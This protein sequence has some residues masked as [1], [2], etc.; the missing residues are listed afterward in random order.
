MKIFSLL[1]IACLFS[2]MAIAQPSVAV[3]GFVVDSAGN[4]LSNASIKVKFAKDSLFTQTKKDGSFHFRLQG[5][6]QFDMLITMVGF[7]AHQKKY[8]ITAGDTALAL[9]RILLLPNDME[10]EGVVVVAQTPVKVMEDTTQYAVSA[11]K[12]REGA[13]AEEVIKKLPGLEVDKDGN[14]TSQGKPVKRI[15]V[16]GKDFFGGD[17]QTATQ[18]LPAEVLENIQIIEDY[19]DQANLTGIKT[20]EPETIININTRKDKNRGKFGSL[21]AGVGTRDRYMAGLMYNIFDDEQQISL[22]GSFNN[23]NVATFNFNGGGRGGGARAGNLGGAERG[24]FGG[25]GLT[26]AIS[27]GINYRDKWNEKMSVDGSYSVNWSSNETISE[28]QSQD[29]NPLI[30]RITKSNRVSESSN[31]NHRF[32]F[33]FDYR[34]D[35]VNFLK[36]T[37]YFSYSHNEGQNQSNSQLRRNKYYTYNVGRSDNKSYAPNYGGTVLFNHKFNQR[38]RNLSISLSTNFSARTQAG[39][40]LNN[41][42]NIDSGYVPPSI[43]DTIQQQQSETLSD[44]LTSNARI[45]Y[46]EPLD[47]KRNKFL[48]MSYEWN[49]SANFSDRNVFDVLQTSKDPLP[50][51]N[52]SN[53][54]NYQFTTHRTALT[55]KGMYAK[56]N[57]LV[58][59]VAQPSLLNGESV[60]KNIRIN[61]RNMN[62][63]PSARFAYNIG[64]DHTINM[65]VGGRSREPSFN[66]LQPISDSSNLNNIVKGNP[67]LNAET[68]YNLSIRYNKSDRK[69][70]KVLFANFNYDITDDKIVSAR[71]NNVSGTG[72]TTTYMNTDGFYRIAA[73]GSF[74]QPFKKRIFSVTT[75]LDMSYDN[76]ISFTDSFQNK[77]QNW[78]LR[79]GLIF[80]LDI[81]EV[82]DLNFDGGFTYYKTTT[83]YSTY[84]TNNEARTYRIGVSGKHFFFK[85]LTIG[86][87]LYKNFNSGFGSVGAVN[88]FIINTYAEYRFLKGKVATVRFQAYDLL[89]QNTGIN[90]IINETTITDSRTN[91]LSRFFFL[92]FSYRLMKFAAGAKKAPQRPAAPRPAAGKPAGSQ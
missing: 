46:T 59:I 1:T 12:V 60:E 71:F 64:K 36:I 74:T 26:Q 34:M 53:E 54:L 56:Y 39:N 31:S 91:R 58:G 86:Y 87:D 42:R 16:N 28:N 66:Q 43:R 85:D 67:D 27:G 48:E 73:N 2:F 63:L 76:N 5:T 68:T 49:R 45:S 89:D 35:S 6:P 65:N 41:Y 62:W 52:Q 78:N 50:N 55:F 7:A 80:R 10:L 20:G 88:P 33:N 23:T 15:R 14:I 21:S 44:N 72:R 84:T 9:G 18:N 70:G 38:S 79:P 19:G 75:K 11:F 22:L 4:L 51:I 40:T 90:R 81:P 61:Y 25:N 13:M 69:T 30:N 29:I 47:N 17:V 8:S 77:G 82:I 37:P 92:T 83:R 3:K 24:G 57:Y 32:T